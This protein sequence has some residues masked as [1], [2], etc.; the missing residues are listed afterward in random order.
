MHNFTRSGKELAHI[1]T[2]QS[3]PSE[4]VQSLYG[5]LK[6][7]LRPHVPFTAAYEEDILII[8]SV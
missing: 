5:G 4:L 8:I 1:Y 3:L 6:L 7:H 2:S